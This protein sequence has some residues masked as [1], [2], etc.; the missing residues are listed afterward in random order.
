MKKGD[1]GWKGDD[2]TP[3]NKE[4]KIMKSLRE[5]IK[6]WG[7]VFGVER[8]FFLTLTFK[9]NVTS[10]KEAQKRFNNFNRQFSRLS[11]VTW[12]Y[13]GIEPQERGA[14]HFHII[15]FHQHNLGGD[16]IDWEAYKKAGE[17][18]SQKNWGNMYKY[19]RLAFKGAN[20]E[21]REMWKKVGSIAEGSK[22]GRPEFLPVRSVHSI[23]QYVGKYLGKCFAQKN[24]GNWAQG[25]RRFSYSKKAPQV[26]GR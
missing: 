25:L 19:Q 16:Q 4:Y 7:K 3:D 10:A 2:F 22:M 21:L 23:G 17:Y 20:E 11:K 9:D 6:H 14:L 1:K 15:G 8:L 12:L 26:H 18:R 24:N 5:N 13:K